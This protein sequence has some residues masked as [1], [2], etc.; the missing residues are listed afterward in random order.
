MFIDEYGY[1]AAIYSLTYFVVTTISVYSGNNPPP[2]WIW[3]I[4]CFLL[5]PI[6]LMAF[7]RIADWIEKKYYIYKKQKNSEL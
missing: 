2:G 5:G 3:L 7:Y 4:I 1:Y 6:C